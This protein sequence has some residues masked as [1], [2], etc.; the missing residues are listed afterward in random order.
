MRRSSIL[1]TRVLHHGM[2]DAHHGK[3]IERQVLDEMAEG[4]LHRF[5]GLEVIEML[6]IDIG[7]DRDLGR[8]LQERAVTLVRFDHHP[9]A[10][11]KP[12]IR[13][14]GVDDAAID[15]GGIE[16]AGIEQRC[17]HRGR[18]G[19]AVGAGDGDAALQPHQLGQH[20]GAA[21]HRNAAFARRRQFR[22]VALD[23]G[24]DHDDLRAVDVLRLVAD[25]DPRAVLAQTVEI[26]IVRGVRALHGIAEIEQHLGDAAHADPAD[27]DEVDG[28]DLAR[29]SHALFP[30][31]AAGKGGI[32][33]RSRQ[34]S[35]APFLLDAPL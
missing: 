32:W 7:D 5:E 20:L 13:A 12:R 35:R 31:L 10:G 17:D 9:V 19:L 22:I 28:S 33:R 1:P 16:A 15:H 8:Q 14:I 4:V 27:P 11:A 30:D 6:G 21:H 34:I 3:A 24:G 2:I 26:V 18:G 25:R 23:R 29:Q